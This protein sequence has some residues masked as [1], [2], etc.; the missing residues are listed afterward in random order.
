MNASG[1]RRKFD[2]D[3]YVRRVESLEAG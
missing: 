2:P 3:A 1:L